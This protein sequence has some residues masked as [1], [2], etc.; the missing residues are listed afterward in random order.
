MQNAGR[1]WVKDEYCIPSS[2]RRVMAMAISSSRS[3]TPD[4][5]EFIA[6]F[7]AIEQA[8]GVVQRDRREHQVGRIVVFG[9]KLGVV[10]ALG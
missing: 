8:L 7:Q 3:V 4:I 6:E 1:G 10:A 9:K 2:D 5:T